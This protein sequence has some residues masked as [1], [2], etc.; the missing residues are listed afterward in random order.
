MNKC[1][2]ELITLD[3]RQER[4]DYLR[5]KGN[6]G[7]ET[8]GKQR[9]LNQLLYRS[10]EWRRFRRKILMRDNGCDMALEG[11]Q[12]MGV[13]VVHHI[14]P[15]TIEDI[16]SND[17]KVFDPENVISVSDETHKAIHY[18]NEELLHNELIERKPN[19]T[20]PWLKEV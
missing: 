16:L 6:I 20:S 10:P 14:V 13:I 11:H 2:S 3:T 12:I 7:Y 15:I 17:P 5:L 18:S 4:F 1:Y 9:Y 19:D 8:F